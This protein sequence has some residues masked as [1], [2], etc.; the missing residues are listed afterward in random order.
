MQEIVQSVI[1]KSIQIVGETNPSD[2]FT[3]CPQADML[4]I[5]LQRIRIVAS[6]FNQVFSMR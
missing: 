5:H 6:V 4:K 3:K 1:L 2:V